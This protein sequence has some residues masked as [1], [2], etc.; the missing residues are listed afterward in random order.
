[1]SELFRSTG[2]LSIQNRWAASSRLRLEAA[3]PPLPHL[4]S[5]RRY[6]GLQS[7]RRAEAKGD[8]LMSDLYV[9]L[10]PLL[11]HPSADSVR[12][13]PPS[14][15]RVWSFCPSH[16]DGTKYGKRSLSL[17]PT[18]GLNC[19]AGCE[20]RDVVQALRE[21]AGVHPTH[22]APS[23]PYRSGNGARSGQLGRVTGSWIYEAKDRTP[24]FRVVRLDNG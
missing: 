5:R 24:L 11:D 18:I 16:A 13:R 2:G 23:T 21:R 22:P 4:F 6:V 7:R 20:F 3:R 12:E 14:G 19:F 17:H 8:G 9:E 1:M 15:G 10:L